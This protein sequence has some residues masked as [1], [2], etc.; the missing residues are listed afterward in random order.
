MKKWICCLL[1]GTLVLSSY[2]SAGTSL[3]CNQNVQ[4]PKN[5]SEPEFIPTMFELTVTV[6]PDGTHTFE[7]DAH[8]WTINNWTPTQHH[9]INFLITVM[10]PYHNTGSTTYSWRIAEWIAEGLIGWIFFW[11][12]HGNVVPT[13]YYQP[14]FFGTT[15]MK[16]N[17]S[18]ADPDV[19]IYNETIGI[20]INPDEACKICIWLCPS[21]GRRGYF[22][23]FQ[24]SP[25]EDRDYF[26]LPF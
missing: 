13:D 19:K 17:W 22:A 5:A 8:H 15:K 14:N 1:C 4:T 20:D 7:I 11:L 10:N 18:A 12:K 3:N 9:E 6:K 21:G 25:S 26:T 16:I 23:C 24:Y 2:L